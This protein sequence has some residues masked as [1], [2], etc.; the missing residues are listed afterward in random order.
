[1]RAGRTA[2]V[3]LLGAMLIG[4]A[5]PAAQDADLDNV[6]ARLAAYLL[7]YEK[8]LTSVVAEERYVQA[9]Y[10]H[11][12]LNR[13]FLLRQRRLQ[14]DIAFLR[15][16]GHSAWFGVRDVRRV[17]GR[18][19][20]DGEGRLVS[21][22]HAFD[23]RSLEAAA[24]IVARS[25]A[26][27]LGTMRTINV[28]TVPLEVLQP[29]HHVQF[30]FK[31]AGRLRIG[32]TQTVRVDFEEFDEPTIIQGTDGGS[33]FIAGSAWIDPRSGALWRA[34]LTMS[35][36]QDP[37]MR[38]RFAINQLRVDFTRHR[39]LGMMVP[40]RMT[41]VFWIDRGRGEGDAE[42]FN[43]RRFT[44]SARIVPPGRD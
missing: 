7:A 9:E 5:A 39:D 27:N 28:P 40:K 26:H 2:T 33:V 20:A 19:V 18:S 21:I 13:F 25:A 8:E 30:A 41:E 37:A 43:F 44:T 3:C 38:R 17:D 34:D 10:R 4:T 15:L 24:Q 22:L 32:G 16:P 42:Y 6:L 11:V 23:E 14:S 1:M 35:P 12:T 31:V 29:Q 36:H